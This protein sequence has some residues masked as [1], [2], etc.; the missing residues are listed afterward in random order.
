MKGEGGAELGR[1]RGSE[2]W[3]WSGA[4]LKGDRGVLA[5]NMGYSARNH[6]LLTEGLMLQGLVCLHP[7]GSSACPPGDDKG[8]LR[9]SLY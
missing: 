6:V 7:M 3:D 4:A 2:G 8:G 1:G 5:V 9:H